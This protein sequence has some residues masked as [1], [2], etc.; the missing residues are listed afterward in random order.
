MIKLSLLFSLIMTMNNFNSSIGVKPQPVQVGI[1]M[2]SDESRF[3]ELVNKERADRDLNQL[4]VDPILVQV[5]RRH[6][7]EMAEK[8]YFSHR[9]PT[10]ASRTPMDRYMAEMTGEP[11]WLMVGENLFYCS[12]VDVDRGHE[13]FM[14]SPA[15]KANIVDHRYERIGVGEYVTSD[16]ELYVTEMFLSRSG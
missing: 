1:V 9:S 6:S 4:A 2:S 3:A 12:V 11:L 14:Q 13:A 5:A 8:H 7:R 16:G 10:P 15:H